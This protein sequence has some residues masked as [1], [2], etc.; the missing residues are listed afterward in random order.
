[1]S[2]LSYKKTRL[3]YKKVDQFCPVWLSIFSSPAIFHFE[4]PTVPDKKILH[5]LRNGSGFEGFISSSMAIYSSKKAP[6]F[7]QL[8]A[9]EFRLSKFGF[10]SGTKDNSIQNCPL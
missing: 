3:E 4:E 9:N 10:D 5:F 8:L 2:Q 6:F 1:M 7:Q